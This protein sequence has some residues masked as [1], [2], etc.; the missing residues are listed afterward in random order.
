MPA[1]CTRPAKQGG[2]ENKRL[3]SFP[4]RVLRLDRARSLGAV[5]H[6]SPNLAS[7]VRPSPKLRFGEGEVT[8]GAAGAENKRPSH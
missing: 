6:P 8:C 4:G 3:A 2:S 5:G 7:L 1:A